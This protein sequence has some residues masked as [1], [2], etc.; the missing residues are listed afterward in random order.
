MSEIIKITIKLEND[1]TL[2]KEVELRTLNLDDEAELK[3]LFMD[4]YSENMA[5]FE[6]IGNNRAVAVPKRLHTNSLRAIR[7]ATNYTD[8]EI[9]E[10]PDNSRIEIFNI[11]M[12]RLYTKKK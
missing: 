3:D 8:E 9:T 11:I 4:Y 7:L 12:D 1:K 10:I 6:N 5:F 2:E